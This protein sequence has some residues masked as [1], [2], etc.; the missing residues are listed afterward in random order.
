MQ[1]SRR[2]LNLKYEL[3]VYHTLKEWQARG[4]RLRDHI[5]IACGLKPDLRKQRLRP[6][7]LRALAY[8]GDGYVIERLAVESLP[9]Y[10]VT[11]SLFLPLNR[12]L[13]VPVMLHPHGHFETGRLND[14]DILRSVALAKAGCAVLLY[15]MIGY[16]DHD[17]LPHR[18]VNTPIEQ[19]WG[20][21]RAGLQLRNS[22]IFVD[23]LESLIE[24]DANRI[25]CS[26]ISGGGTQTF[27][28]AAV[29]PRIKIA[30]PV[31]MVSARMQGGCLCE[32][33]P[34]LRVSA[35]NPEIT[36]LFAPKPLLLIS[37]S[38]DWTDDNPTV[39]EPFIRS[40]Y[41]LCRAEKNFQRLHLSEGHQFGLP[42]REVYYQWV[43][44]HFKLES[45]PREPALSPQSLV[46]ALKVWGQ[47]LQKPAQAA[48][49]N[50]IFDHFVQDCR[51]A[52]PAPA[53]KRELN[54][55]RQ[56]ATHALS[57]AFN[58]DAEP[59]GGSRR[60]TGKMILL[61]GES[62]ACARWEEMLKSS[63]LPIQRCELVK[64]A[65]ADIPNF[66]QDYYTTYNPAPDAVNVKRLL[67]KLKTLPVAQVH[68]IGLGKFALTALYA[69]ALWGGKGKFLLATDDNESDCFTPCLE[70]AGG[71]HAAWILV[72]P[73]P[74]CLLSPTKETETTARASYALAGA[75]KQIL[76][77]ARIEASLQWLLNESR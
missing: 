3:P 16:N 14:A 67:E 59:V 61:A 18:A 77:T 13:P 64:T 9:N 29:D 26:G 66:H 74:L 38:G 30:S 55:Y 44:A 15:D 72:A 4:K 2:H 37:D 27:L 7:A 65:L 33:A 71:Q 70:R 45:L 57:H 60:K 28:L 54:T 68:L 25:G 51:A 41:K 58:L 52:F 50:A 21:S 73:T 10:Y 75:E 20:Y 8:E 56:T 5:E 69:R 76:V 19:L 32:N 31:K 11:G 34:N 47:D 49:E 39:V 23:Y 36:A 48:S 53:H 12:K 17:Q 62:E 6:R 43:H 63:G 22:L 42:A 24:I 35:T 1:I 46:P 40:I